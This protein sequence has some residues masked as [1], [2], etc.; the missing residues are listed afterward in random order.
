MKRGGSGNFT[1]ID[2]NG[3]AG[4]TET[5]TIEIG[6]GPGRGTGT[7]TG[8]NTLAPGTYN[9]GTLSVDVYPSNL[10]LTVDILDIE[11]GEQTQVIIPGS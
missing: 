8:G 9:F 6:P 11:T 1:P 5:P 7:G 4:A 2:R 3:F 10:G